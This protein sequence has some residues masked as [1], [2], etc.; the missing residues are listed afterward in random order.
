[1]LP[2]DADEHSVIARDGRGRPA[3]VERVAGEGRM[4]LCTYPVELHAA[5]VPFVDRSGLVRLY[6]ALG[7]LSGAREVVTTSSDDVFADLLRHPDGAEFA[8]VVSQSDQ[9]CDFQLT[10]P[11][12]T[13]DLSLPPLGAT[14]VPLSTPTSQR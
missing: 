9:R 6:R 1:M 7:E 5:R 3:I 4:L 14:V 13:R 10:T 11:R 2:V 8:V 12:G